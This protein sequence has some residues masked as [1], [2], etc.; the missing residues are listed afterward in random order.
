MSH[1]RLKGA[2]PEVQRA[3]LL[4]IV[5]DSPVLMRT[6]HLARDMALPDWWLVSGAIYGQVWN[7]LTDRPEMHGVKDIDLF[8]FDPDTSYAAEDRQIRRAAALFPPAPPV[9]LR[10]Q[11]RVPLWYP[12]HFGRTYPAIR[13]S[14]GAIDLFACTTHCVG[15]RLEADDSLTL[16]APYG[17]EPI[18][19]FRLE[20]NTRLDNRA[21]HAAKAER[22]QRHWPELTVIPWP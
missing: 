17:L 11:A 8:Y 18:F 1:L 3:A 7:A 5:G 20:P 22:Q 16:Y 4:G 21:T 19:A 13:T 15:L 9:E 12:A 6:L 2:D 14:A 10:N